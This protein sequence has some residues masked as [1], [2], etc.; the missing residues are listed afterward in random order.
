MIGNADHAA[1]IAS[2]PLCEDE[3]RDWA[4]EVPEGFQYLS[5]GSY[6]HAFL[7][8]DGVVYKRDTSL[9]EEHDGMGGNL[10]EWDHYCKAPM[11][12]EGVRFAM[13]A[14]YGEI[15]AMEYVK[16][17]S[18]GLTGMQ[19]DVLARI[20]IFDVFGNNVRTKDG[21][22]ILTDFAM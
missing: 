18:P 5:S 4:G 7:G 19:R 1:T 14:L 12:P 13:T 16:D 8:P 21:E 20:G 17:C 3:W 2:L 10:S 15:I 11:L 9:T 22:V 6:R